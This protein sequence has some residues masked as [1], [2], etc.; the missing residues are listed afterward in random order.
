MEIIY[1]PT[2]CKEPK[3]FE[4][5]IKLKV[6]NFDERFQFIEDCGLDVGDDGGLTKKTGNFAIIRNMVKHSEKFYVGVQLVRLED[7]KEFNNFQDLCMDPGCDEILIEVAKEIRSG[8]RPS[9]K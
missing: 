2:V 3:T 1:T 6:P 4:G 8:F 9:S 5:A 7:R